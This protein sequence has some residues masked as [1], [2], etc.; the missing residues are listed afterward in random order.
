MSNG[1]H[2]NKLTPAQAER[3]AILMEEMAE[4]QQVIG[5]ILRHGLES[6]HPETE[7]CNRDLLAK[8]LGHV[9]YAIHMLTQAG[10]LN[11]GY[12]ASCSAGKRVSIARYL[13]HQGAH[14]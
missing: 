10:D 13:H 11:A 6:Y 12:M 7:E 5:K 4:A 8:E 9:D 14:A 3:F 2:F 1:H